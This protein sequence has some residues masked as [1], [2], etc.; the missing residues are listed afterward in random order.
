MGVPEL[1]NEP[2]GYALG[3]ARSLEPVRI[4]ACPGRTS[5]PRSPEALPHERAAADRSP[6]GPESGPILGPIWTTWGAQPPFP[7]HLHSGS[8]STNFVKFALPLCPTRRAP[9]GVGGLNGLAPTAADPEGKPFERSCDARDGRTWASQNSQTSPRDTLLA[10]PEASG[11]SA[12][13][14]ARAGRPSPGVPKRSR[15]SGLQRIALPSGPN[16][17]RS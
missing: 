15:T 11:P 14:L 3:T 16:R 10:Q 5:Q 9:A 2:S 7:K 12:S 1:A 4:A 13:R 17:A 6:I 8:N